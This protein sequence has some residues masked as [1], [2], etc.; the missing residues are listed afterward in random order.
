MSNFVVIENGIVINHIIA[1][2]L[3]IAQEVT[4]KL[5]IQVFPDTDVECV[6]IGFSYDETTG[7]FTNTTPSPYPSW[8]LV[9][10]AWTAPVPRPKDVLSVWDE[11]TVSWSII[12]LADPAQ[13][14]QNTQ[15]NPS[16]QGTQGVTPPTN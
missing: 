1:E 9:N 15:E 4:G 13:A 7:K 16:V 2:S 10:N 11:E 3:E 12:P 6:D 5:C 8:V 14:V